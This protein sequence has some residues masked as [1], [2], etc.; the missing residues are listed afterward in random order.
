MLTRNLMIEAATPLRH[1]VNSN[2][3]VRR[4]PVQTG[5]GHSKPACPQTGFRAEVGGRQRIPA[6]AI[7]APCCYLSIIAD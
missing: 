1:A 5:Q 3:I 7:T 6:F 2:A 4:A